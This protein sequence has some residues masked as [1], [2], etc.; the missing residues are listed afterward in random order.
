MRAWIPAFAGMTRGGVIP[1]EDGIQGCPSGS[2]N[3]G[4]SLRKQGSRL[5][6]C[7]TP[8]RAMTDAEAESEG[9]DAVF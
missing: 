7:V 3:P 1:S 2:W 6:A 4:L 5:Y 8:G 9:F